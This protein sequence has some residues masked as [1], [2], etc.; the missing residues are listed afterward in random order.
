MLWNWREYPQIENAN[1][2]RD[3]AGPLG[4][5]GVGSFAL[6]GI[7]GLAGAAVSWRAGPPAR[8][9]LGYIVLMSIGM[10]PFFVTD[11]YRHHLVPALTLLAALVLTRILEYRAA[12]G[13]HVAMAFALGAAALFVFLP[14]PGFSRLRYEWALASDRSTRW[15]EKGRPDLALVEMEKAER[16]EAEDRGV[17]VPGSALALERGSLYFNR[18]LV[19]EDLGRGT[20]A[21]VWF[22]RAAR[23][24]PDNAL[25]VR[26]LADK[27]RLAGRVT[28]AESLYARLPGLVG[29][30]ARLISSRAWQSAQHGDLEG[31]AQ[32]FEHAIGVDASLRESWV[33]WIRVEI[34]RGRLDT[35]AAL[36]ER[37]R[38]SSISPPTLDSYE[39]LILALRGDADGARRLLARVPAHTERDPAVA[40]AVRMT[41]E[42][43]PR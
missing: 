24:A 20:E 19:L 35:A 8:F 34:Q 28:E 40:E 31:A 32:L 15:M 22:E 18:A 29:G 10:L 21:F 30:D 16:L 41:R 39:A 36:I 13:R 5:P 7:L 23:I 26:S 17:V 42:R 33:G 11:R 25:A 4:I 1:E 38:R 3:D 27:H 43:L 14:A 6:L 37:A 2:F 12:P 9:A